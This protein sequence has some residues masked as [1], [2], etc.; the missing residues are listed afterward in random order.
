MYP[1]RCADH[2]VK[3]GAAPG[4][5]KAKK[6]LNSSATPWPNMFWLVDP[7]DQIRVGRL[8]H[9]GY[10]KMWAT[11]TSVWANSHAFIKRHA[12]PCGPRDMPQLG[13]WCP[14]SIGC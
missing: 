2:A 6:W 3:H 4:G 7:T 9:Q 13:Y 12:A 8:E 11:S 10:V 5:G 14:K 1:L